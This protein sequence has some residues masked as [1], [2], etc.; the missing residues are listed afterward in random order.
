MLIFECAA[1]YTPVTEIVI[2]CST[3]IQFTNRFLGWK[4]D[5]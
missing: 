2:T 3:V 4:V 1:A 5:L